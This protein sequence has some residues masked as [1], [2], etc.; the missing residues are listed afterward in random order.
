MAIG[1]PRTKSMEFAAIG[2][3]VNDSTVFVIPKNRIKAID[4][5]RLPVSGTLKVLEELWADVIAHWQSDY[6]ERK[7][8]TSA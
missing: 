8:L 3:S 7:I 2:W 5:R 6:T 1:T 4:A